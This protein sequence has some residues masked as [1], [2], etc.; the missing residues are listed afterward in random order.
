MLKLTKDKHEA[1]RDFSATAELLVVA[2][3]S[4]G[5]TDTK[6]YYQWGAHSYIA[7]PLVIKF[8]ISGR[9]TGNRFLYQWALQ[10]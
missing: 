9:L 3:T 6:I 7:P 5:P 2:I 8:H 4:G 10:R 1:S